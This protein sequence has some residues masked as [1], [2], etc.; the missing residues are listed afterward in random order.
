MRSGR[1]C[2]WFLSS[3]RW[4]DGDQNRWAACFLRL[5]R[6][7]L[8]RL[9]WPRRGKLRCFVLRLRPTLRDLRY[10]LFGVRRRL[11][12]VESCS[13]SW[14]RL[15]PEIAESPHV[16][17]RRIGSL[18]AALEIRVQG[19]SRCR[20]RKRRAHQSTAKIPGE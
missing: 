20:S 4:A 19:Y 8:E 12:A 14:S 9:Q 17:E 11:F 2:C 16:I 15:I 1:S 18:V 6:S 13:R 5:F 3:A 10:L 7:K